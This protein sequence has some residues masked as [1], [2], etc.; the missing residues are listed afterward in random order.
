MC[1][2]KQDCA[3]YRRTG[4]RDRCLVFV[5]IYCDECRFYQTQEEY[6]ERMKED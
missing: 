2:Y 6:E 5:E 4:D 3:F 1:K